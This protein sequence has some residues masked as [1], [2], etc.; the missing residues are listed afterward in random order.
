MGIIAPSIE[1]SEGRVQAQWATNC[2]DSVICGKIIADM[3]RDRSCIKSENKNGWLQKERIDQRKYIHK[4][5]MCV[6][7]GPERNQNP[8]Q[9][10]HTGA[11]ITIQTDRSPGSSDVVDVDLLVFP[12]LES[13][14]TLLVSKRISL[15]DL[16]V[17]GK[18]TISLD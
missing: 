4:S 10:S 8:Q 13:A 3:K 6:K 7:I 11:M 14:F 1:H 16:R 12:E 2:A 17:L 9:L 5:R 15:I 18:F